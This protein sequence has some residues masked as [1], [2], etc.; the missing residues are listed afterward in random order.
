MVVCLTLAFCQ[1]ADICLNWGG[2]NLLAATGQS[3]FF[4]QGKYRSKSLPETYMY[5]C[6]LYQ[7]AVEK[8]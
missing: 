7:K 6:I 8:H 2:P 3:H 1:R 5:S 4:W